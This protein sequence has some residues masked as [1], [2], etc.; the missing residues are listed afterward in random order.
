MQL[1]IEGEGGQ[2]TY[3]NRD[4]TGTFDVIPKY[5]GAQLY[6]HESYV[7]MVMGIILMDNIWIKIYHADGKRH[8]NLTGTPTKS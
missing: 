2:R 6:Y 5:P 8:Q 1:K 7:F 4:F 3:L